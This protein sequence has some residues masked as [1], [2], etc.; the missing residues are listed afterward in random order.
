MR[1]S[2]ELRWPAVV[3]LV[4]F[5]SSCMEWKVQDIGP[6]G[7]GGARIGTGRVVLKDGGEILV[8]DAV[9]RGDSLVGV[10]PGGGGRV[11]LGLDR[12]ARLERRRLSDEGQAVIVVASLA[13]AGWLALLA[14]L[15]A[16]NEGGRS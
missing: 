13:A 1:P 4:L 2:R 16:G 10:G 6:P 5:L 3:T 7:D 9:V 8:S 14:V 11:A 15:H 12:I